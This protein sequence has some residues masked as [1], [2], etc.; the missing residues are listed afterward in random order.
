MGEPDIS[1]SETPRLQE[2]AIV[3]QMVLVQDAVAET[4]DMM[5]SESG[6]CLQSMDRPASV[7]IN[8]HDELAF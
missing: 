7:L 3:G 1:G 8:D 4:L 5:T 6:A 2:N